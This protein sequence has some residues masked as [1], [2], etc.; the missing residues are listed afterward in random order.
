M[1]FSAWQPPADSNRW[2]FELAYLRGLAMCRAGSPA[3]SRHSTVNTVGT[4][5]AAAC[6]CCHNERLASVFWPEG[7]SAMSN[8]APKP[9]TPSPRPARS[10]AGLSSIPSPALSL[11]RIRSKDSEVI[12]SAE[13]APTQCAASRSSAGY[14]APGVLDEPRGRKSGAGPRVANPR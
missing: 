4:A 11:M 14:D 10:L 13:G 3:D 5:I 9:G 7:A 2:R 1:A 12:P 8:C 6:R